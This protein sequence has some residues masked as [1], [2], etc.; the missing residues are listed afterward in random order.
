MN[1]DTLTLHL[2]LSRDGFLKIFPLGETVVKS[3]EEFQINETYLKTKTAEI[4]GLL[5]IAAN[6]GRASGDLKAHEKMRSLGEDLYQELIPAS[7]RKSLEDFAGKNLE[8]RM[9][10]DL[11]RIPWE[12]LHD[13]NA[14][15][16]RR[17]RMG[18]FVHTLSSSV[19]VEKKHPGLPLQFLSIADPE[20]NLPGAF[21]EGKQISDLMFDFD[22]KVEPTLLT[23][24]VRYSDFMD[25]LKRCDVLH[26]A[27]HVEKTDNG[28]QVRFA[29]STCTADQI[30]QL[31]GRFAFPYLVFFNGCQ[32]S[33]PEES[34]WTLEQGQAR[35]FDFA[36]RFLLAGSRNFIGTLWDVD[37]GVAALAGAAFF[38]AFFNGS[39]VGASLAAA[40]DQLISTYG[41]L[42]MVWAGYLHYGNPGF[43]VD[44]MSC[45]AEDLWNEIKGRETRR[46]TYIEL[47]RSNE[48]DEKLAA[49]IALHQMGDGRG[50]RVL[51]KQF[52]RILDFMNDPSQAIRE[53]GRLLIEILSGSNWDFDI[54]EDPKSQEETLNRIREWW[55]SE[56][57]RQRFV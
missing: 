1:P 48:Q 39:T 3:I 53:R 19:T 33:V 9:H 44:G 35:A 17:F 51:R 52:E 20:G 15:F 36:S 37:D 14:F 55:N 13:G 12:L 32:S 45:D 21:H 2:D 23:H 43:R 8:L 30:G 41:E 42:S 38:R 7:L 11:V 16:C 56:E 26:F 31:A 50:A 10:E 47:L 5:R 46:A 28:S 25:N 6:Q 54:L 57:T 40:Q 18:R 4:L 22:E 34:V 29:D 24:H 27:G 49:A